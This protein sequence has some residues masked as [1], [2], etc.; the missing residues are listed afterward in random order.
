MP[1]IQVKQGP[2]AR[3]QPSTSAALLQRD[4]APAPFA[5]VSMT[6]VLRQ[7]NSTTST[8]LSPC[9]ADPSAPFLNGTKAWQLVELRL[10]GMA[11]G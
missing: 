10:T 3:R 8:E 6:R 7:R 9:A 1:A 5:T 11:G 4:A 2:G